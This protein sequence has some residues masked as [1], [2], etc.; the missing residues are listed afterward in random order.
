MCVFCVYVCV[1][2]YQFVF[3]EKT[4][5][6]YSPTEEEGQEPEFEDRFIGIADLVFELVN[7]GCSY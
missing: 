5:I 6:E 2:S 4:W 1:Y 7:T 3:G